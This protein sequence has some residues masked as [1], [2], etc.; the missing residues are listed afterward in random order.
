MGN[1]ISLIAT[2]SLLSPLPFSR[3]SG[4]WFW[5]SV[6]HI[7]YEG[8]RAMVRLFTLSGERGTMHMGISE[9]LKIL[10]GGYSK[11][12]TLAGKNRYHRAGL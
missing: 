8:E 4:Q 11:I 3:L 5:V 12:L 1:L 6:S 10:N 7:R 9:D 2:P